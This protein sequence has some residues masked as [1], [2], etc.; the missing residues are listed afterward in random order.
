ML[1][2][3][4]E[5]EILVGENR[6]TRNRK[7]VG[8]LYRELPYPSD[9]QMQDLARLA[10]VDSSDSFNKHIR[11]IILDAHLLDRSYRGLSAPGVKNK[12]K[13]V[14]DKADALKEALKN[15]DIG[16]GSSAD[17]AGLILELALSNFKFR[18]G[19]ASV[20]EY[21]VLL[22]ELSKAASQAMRRAKAKRGPKGGA[23]GN[24][25]F[26]LFI[27]HLEMAAWQRRL[28][29]GQR[30][31]APPDGQP[32]FILEGRTG[33]A[34][35]QSGYW[36]IFLAPDKKTWSGSLSEALDILKL[37]LP[38][39]FFPPVVGRAAQH[40]RTKFRSQIKIAHKLEIAA[41][42]GPISTAPGT[43]AHTTKKGSHRH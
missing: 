24:F 10:H 19:M 15:I 29:A 7:R 6:W 27:Q 9:S 18:E 16:S 37:Y 13:S 41:T 21:V 22:T 11:S 28:A 32:N 14:R 39:K 4:P 2:I 33:D 34:W 3:T 43:E 12:L 35:Q 31:R 20:P 36:T 8:K 40:A 1:E 5:M 25:A 23:G 17:R 38:E 30:E 42:R 26:N